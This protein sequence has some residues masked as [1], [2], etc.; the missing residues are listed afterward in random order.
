VG[1]ELTAKVMNVNTEERRIGLS[2]KRLEFED[3]ESLLKDYVTN[4]KP[5]TSSFGEILS[6]SLQEKLNDKNGD[7]DSPNKK[8]SGEEE[9]G[10]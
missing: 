6:E 1:D 7:P 8:T 4:M 9:T 10:E 3:E 5:A 2:I